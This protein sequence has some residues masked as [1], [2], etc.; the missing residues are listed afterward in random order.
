M[1]SMYHSAYVATSLGV[2]KE[3]GRDKLLNL[4]AKMGFPQHEALKPHSAMGLYYKEKLNEKL[5][6]HAGRYNMP[7]L[8]FPSFARRY[9]YKMAVSASDAI[10]SMSSLLDCG[11]EWVRQY[12]RG[13][14]I[15]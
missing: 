5:R 2:W 13:Y 7:H 14:F 12:A 10:Y 3:K 9:G 11:S 4:L 15:Y 1:D 6:D 8:A